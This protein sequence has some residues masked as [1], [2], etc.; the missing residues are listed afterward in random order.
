M[1][2]VAHTAT[3]VS[4]TAAISAA[5]VASFYSTDTTLAQQ[6]AAL[7]TVMTVDGESA[8]FTNGGS[9]YLFVESAGTQDTLIK[10][11]GVTIT[12]DGATITGTGITGIGA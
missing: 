8:L 2:I 5:G 11:T 6:I 12:T 9:T 3:A 7:K 1:S 4:G 10:L